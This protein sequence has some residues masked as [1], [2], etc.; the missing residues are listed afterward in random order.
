[1]GTLDGKFWARAGLVAGAGAAAMAGL[2]PGLALLGGLGFALALGDPWEGRARHWSPRLLALAVVALGA[3]MDL[4]VV[5]RSGLHGLGITAA[6]ISLTL[7]LAWLLS[8]LW[9][10]DGEVSALIG[11]G[12]AIC[13]GSAI[14]AVAPVLR[15]RPRDTSVAL[16]AV[17]LLNAAALWI[18]P[19]V[20][21]RL[22]MGQ[23]AF[24]LWCALAIH[25]TSSVVGASLSYGRAAERIAITVKLA[26]ALWIVPVTL[27]AGWYA[28]RAA[29]GAAGEEP[30]P[31]PRRPWFILGFL[32]AA[33]LAT[34][35]PALRPLG[36]EVAQAGQRALLAALFLIGAGFDR[37]SLASVGWRPLAL[38][39]SLWA[40]V[41]SASLA[42]IRAG[43]I[44]P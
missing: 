28:D 36:G 10:T 8:R 23:G 30:R 18:F 32:G 31:K 5:A 21:H 14:A 19:W 34:A 37:R 22:G 24:G 41:A 33:A 39:L 2:S 1:M 3:G 6:G 44:R 11:V 13:W 7:A 4:G 12:T 26:R 9:R 29:T 16:G 25:D 20:G 38:A 42:V 27:A 17:F 40:V 15:T 43:W 35:V